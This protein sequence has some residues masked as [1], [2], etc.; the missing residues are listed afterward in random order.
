MQLV[1]LVAFAILV[2]AQVLSSRGIWRSVYSLCEPESMLFVLSISVV[3]V[4]ISMAAPF[5]GSLRFSILIACTL[6]LARIYMSVVPVHEVFEAFCYAA[7]ISVSIFTLMAVSQLWESIS[8]LA[9]FNVFSFSPN[10]L[11][12]IF[13]S[14][15]VIFAWKF[16]MSRWRG[17]TIAA[18]CATMSLLVILFASSRASILAI[19]MGGGGSLAL[20]ALRINRAGHT[21]LLHIALYLSMILAASLPFI[22]KV[23]VAQATGEF[24]DKVLMITNPDRGIDSGFT[25]RTAAWSE[26]M[27]VFTNG[28]WFVGHGLKT[29][30]AWGD[31]HPMSIDNSYLVLLYELGLIPALLITA[32]FLWVMSSF[33]RAYFQC[34]D[35]GDKLR[36]LFGMYL[37]VVLLV[38]NF[39][40]RYLFAIGNPFSL[41]ALLLFVTPNDR[42]GLG[43]YGDVAVTGPLAIS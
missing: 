14:Y 24:L 8:T 40:A 27:T 32:R 26:M 31:A 39:F 2:S 3:G 41:F 6:V 37:M 11:G 15:F 34:V 28:S 18:A 35:N 5:E 7:I 12:Y 9:R 25:G 23:G 30:D 13:A 29:A 17:K 20:G 19:A 16:R 42:I 22:S 38:N 33:G 21:R 36:C 4:A 43:R 1:P 10:T